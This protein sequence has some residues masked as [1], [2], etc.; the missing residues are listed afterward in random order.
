MKLPE[1][2]THV[3]GSSEQGDIEPRRATRDR[4]ET[5]WT[6]PD[7]SSRRFL[8]C[9]IVLAVAVCTML[10]MVG[11]AS[12]GDAKRVIIR[13]PALTLGAKSTA[14]GMVALKGDSCGAS[15]DMACYD[16][17]YR[18]CLG[19]PASS[20]WW[21]MMDCI[22]F[23]PS[24]M[25]YW[26]TAQMPDG[27]QLDSITVID[28]E[29][30]ANM[31]GCNNAGGHRFWYELHFSASSAT[32]SEGH[33]V[34]PVATNGY[35]A[36]ATGYTG[37]FWTY[38]LIEGEIL[39]KDRKIVVVAEPAPG[40]SPDH[41]STICF[42]ES[43]S[44]MRGSAYA[45]DICDEKRTLY[46]PSVGL[47]MDVTLDPNGDPDPD[48]ITTYNL[49]VYK[50]NTRDIKVTYLLVAPP[51]KLRSSSGPF[52]MI[53]DGVDDDQVLVNAE[54]E[55]FSSSATPLS[56][57]MKF[58]ANAGWIY[59]AGENNEALFLSFDADCKDGPEDS[60]RLYGKVKDPPQLKFERVHDGWN[61]DIS[62]RVEAIERVYPLE[63]KE[64]PVRI[65]YLNAAG[66]YQGD[67]V[68]TNKRVHGAGFDFSFDPESDVTEHSIDVRPGDPQ[69]VTVYLRTNDAVDEDYRA[70]FRVDNVIDPA[71]ILKAT[72]EA[73]L[74]VRVS[75]VEGDVAQS[76]RRVEN[77]RTTTEY[78]TAN[79]ATG[80]PWQPD[81]DYFA[82]VN[83]S[84][85]TQIEVSNLDLVVHSGG[86]A[87]L[88]GSWTAGLR[89]LSPGEWAEFQI[90][91]YEDSC[92][93]NLYADVSF[94]Y[95]LDAAASSAMFDFTYYTDSCWDPF[96]GLVL[97]PPPPP[98]APPLGP[99]AFYLTS[100][101]N[102]QRSLKETFTVSLSDAPYSESLELDVEV[103]GSSAF[104]ADTSH[105][106][107]TQAGDEDVNVTFRPADYQRHDAT[108]TFEDPDTGQSWSYD[109]EG[110]SCGGH[111]LE[112]CNGTVCSPSLQR[113]AAGADGYQRC[114]SCCSDGERNGICGTQANG[115]PC[116]WDPAAGSAYDADCCGG[117]SLVACP[118]GC[119]PGLQECSDGHC[120]YCCGDGGT[121]GTC[122][123]YSD[124][125]SCSGI[126]GTPRFDADCNCGEY[127]EMAC[128]DGCMPGL[129]A[130][131]NGR[132]RYCCDDGALNGICGTTAGG[133]SCSGLFNSPNFDADC[134]CGGHG[135]PACIDGCAWG[136][137]ECGDGRCWNCCGDGSSNGICGT[138]SDGGSCSGVPGTNR[139]DADCNCGGHGEPACVDGCFSNLQECGDGSCWNCCSD[140]SSNG[141]CGIYSDGGS[142]SAIPGSNRY[143]TD[144][145]CGGHSQY[146]CPDGCLPGFQ[147]CGDGRCWY[148]CGDGSSN[149][150]C[151]TYSDGGSCSAVPGTNRYDADCD[152]GDHAEPACSDGCLSGY[153][154]CGDGNC[155]N[156]CGDG[157]H[158]GICGVAWDGTSCTS[159]PGSS[160]YDADCLPVS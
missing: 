30:N 116:S 89:L 157:T 66:S 20:N 35:A 90:D 112:P 85:S 96:F 41:D 80:L 29:G 58:G 138:Y 105:V 28:D 3:S 44:S 6:S 135:E 121:N 160:K 139:F 34:L 88:G 47:D 1:Q 8:F 61:E 2:S 9:T 131:S 111:A 64:V 39:I 108:V 136:L 82:V 5:N 127:N 101:P 52:S 155:W 93:A 53:V 110:L 87:S 140:G 48:S 65:S 37:Y 145:S 159:D 128:V 16:P 57:Q 63:T 17:F 78:H 43:G 46:E 144:C 7:V 67:L 71:F 146:A 103:A 81:H 95:R 19:E 49:K 152:C 69:V 134:D 100:P 117:W 62:G 25:Q 119:L 107:V 4:S 84:N 125:G 91:T 86:Q 158:N 92:T 141:I 45:N 104:S 26:D 115:Q 40:A 21:C 132:C 68:L 98:S 73:P 72:T 156:C 106:V 148:C 50:E 14:P 151:G 133:V 33:F 120:W 154:E 109:L 123:T 56:L 118:S 11:A 113:C 114:Y 143:D 79:P 150:L 153:Q 59:T 42:F 75:R 130:C 99:N 77:H 54:L 76:G 126:P 83:V 60:L 10:A 142:C 18:A 55:R 122:G 94:E 15:T 27:I 38:D 147:E 97:P 24:A 102:G 32:P 22:I 137:Q 31:W 12:A 51:G 124:G 23:Y 70:R 13:P 36:T 129:Q 149:G 74:E